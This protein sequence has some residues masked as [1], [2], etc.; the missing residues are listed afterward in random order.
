V[1]LADPRTGNAQ[2]HE[3]LEILLIALAATLSGGRELR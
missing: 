2:R 1:D 3:L